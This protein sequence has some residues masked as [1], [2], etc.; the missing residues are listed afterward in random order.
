MRGPAQ[1]HDFAHIRGAPGLRLVDMGG[2][3][4]PPTDVPPTRGAPA[5]RQVDE[6]PQQLV[7]QCQLDRCPAPRQET[8]QRPDASRYGLLR[9]FGKLLPLRLALCC[10]MGFVERVSVPGFRG[11]VPRLIGVR[12]FGFGTALGSLIGFPRLHHCEGR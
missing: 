12:F 5:A 2:V 10:F 3:D 4:W 6:M 9:C 11:V 7:A 1:R 8:G